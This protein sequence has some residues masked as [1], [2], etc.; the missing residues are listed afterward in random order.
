M[1]IIVSVILLLYGLVMLL[2]CYIAIFP[3]ENK[4]SNNVRFFVK[5]IEDDVPWLYIQQKTG[6][7]EL[8]TCTNNFASYGLN[9]ED[10]AN[11]KKGEVKEMFINLED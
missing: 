3:K 9:P 8:V 4:P 5:A 10:F 6:K 2:M 11:M 1:K 7:L